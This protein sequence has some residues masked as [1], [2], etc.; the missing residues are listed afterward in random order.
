MHFPPTP[1]LQPETGKLTPET[2]TL[3]HQSVNLP[4]THRLPIL[5][6]PHLLCLV[7]FL[8]PQRAESI[9]NKGCPKP[10]KPQ[11]LSV[12]LSHEMQN[13]TLL[14]THTPLKCSG[15]KQSKHQIKSKEHSAVKKK[16][17]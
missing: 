1:S 16:S 6:Q 9:L 10:Y 14:L 8:L 5:Y 12:T 11:H 15:T 7:Y 17:K 13:F 2:L 4:V 3:A